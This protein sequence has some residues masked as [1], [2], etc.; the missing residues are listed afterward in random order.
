MI[1][2]D[3][4]LFKSLCSLASSD[5]RYREEISKDFSFDLY[6]LPVHIAR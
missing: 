3:L 2:T 1:K 5:S 4:A 6:L